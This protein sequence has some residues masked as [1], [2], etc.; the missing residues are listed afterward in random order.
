MPWSDPPEDAEILQAVR[1]LQAGA[2]PAAF[3]PIY[4]RFRRPLTTFFANQT[5]LCE[6][7]EDLAQQTLV[8]AYEKIHQFRFE[9]RF[10][11][12][13]RQIGENVWLNALRDGKAVKRA[14][15]L[16]PLEAP[17]AEGPGGGATRVPDLAPTPEEAA[18]AGE[19]SR[20]LQA[21]V[22]AL[23]AGMRTCTELRVYQD[24]PD[25]EIS[26][27]TGIGLN[28]VRSQLYE[29]RK[30]LE[31]LLAKYFQGAGF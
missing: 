24:L 4:R 30:R 10:Q 29:A 23:P 1:D 9:A 3:E 7:A 22:E 28:T 27:V 18:L 11:T 19:R 26:D 15:R 31:P 20:V 6:D 13:L 14:A 17:D 2:G 21:A 8:K 16:V 25:R 12:W 5:A